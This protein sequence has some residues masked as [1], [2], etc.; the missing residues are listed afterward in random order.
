MVVA[1]SVFSVKTLFTCLMMLCVR[2]LVGISNGI[3]STSIFTVEMCS[4]DLRGTFS[5]LES[6]LRCVGSVLVISLG[7]HW[8]WWQVGCSLNTQCCVSYNC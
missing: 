7:L 3:V 2:I 8:R 6:V 1:S 5:M 4:P